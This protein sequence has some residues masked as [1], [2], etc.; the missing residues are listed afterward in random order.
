MPT[1][2]RQYVMS[3]TWMRLS[4]SIMAM[5]LPSMISFRSQSTRINS[6]TASFPSDRFMK[7]TYSD[8]PRETLQPAYWNRTIKRIALLKQYFKTHSIIDIRTTT[9]YR[10]VNLGAWAYH[11]QQR[12]Q[13]GRL[14]KSILNELEK[15]KGWLWEMP[16][17]DSA[18]LFKDYLKSH[19]VSD[20]KR[21]TVYKEFHVGEWVHYQR[22]SYHEGKLSK[23]AIKELAKI[24]GWSWHPIV[25]QHMRS[26]RLLRAYIDKHG[27]NEFT[28]HT[29]IK[30]VNIGEY[31]K[32][33]RKHFEKGT[34][35]KYVVKELN[36][37][38]G[39]RW[40]LA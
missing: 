36:D 3:V 5:L 11:K 24:K 25:D 8:K 18:L 38:P 35:P 9:T 37:I 13:D 14:H 40:A 1:A 2:D 17:V 7:R 20:I 21:R 39:W 15:V 29:V 28:R 34:L 26:I 32:T 12:Y 16:R 33:C 30:D 19:D 10:G 4:S 31:A 23:S 6:T 27:W 22:R